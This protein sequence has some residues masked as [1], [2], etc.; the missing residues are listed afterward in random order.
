MEE[1]GN[2]LGIEAKSQRIFILSDG[3]GRKFSERRG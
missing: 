3:R 2:I 1:A